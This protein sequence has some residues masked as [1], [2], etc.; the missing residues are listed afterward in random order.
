[1]SNAS[2]GSSEFWYV[3]A[4]SPVR[5]LK[6]AAGRTIAYSTT[7]AS[8]H[9]EAL[10]FLKDYGVAAKPTATGGTAATFTPVMS[11]PID[12]GW[13]APPAGIAAAQEGKIRI[14]ARGNELPHFREQTIRLL[15]AHA[16][17]LGANRDVAARFIQAY[18]DTLEWMY[19]DPSALDAY[20]KF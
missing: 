15:V 13:P 6:D 8:S 7:G 11:G 1:I 18:R 9:M 12:I 2:T 5:S 4:S 19:S 10:A 16:G 14:I 17:W 3:S 20:A